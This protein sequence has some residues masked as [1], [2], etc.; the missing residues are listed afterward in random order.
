MSRAYST[1]GVEVDCL[2]GGQKEKTLGKPR[3]R[4]VD[5]IKMDLRQIG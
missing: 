1:N 2:W 5:N 3:G 4:F